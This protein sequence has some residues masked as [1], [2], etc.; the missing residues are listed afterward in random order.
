MTLALG[1]AGSFHPGVA[2][3]LRT[4]GALKLELNELGAEAGLLTFHGQTAWASVTF[5]GTRHR[6]TYLFEGEEAI[7][8]A[9][10][11]IA[12]LA[13]HEFTV[14][15][16]LVADA[17]VVNVDHHLARGCMTVELELLLLEDA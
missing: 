2:A 14:P 15:G 8:R 3:M 5:S 9:E 11:L 12:E 6:M 10:R 4:E 17:A 1:P 7:A 13:E 16:Q